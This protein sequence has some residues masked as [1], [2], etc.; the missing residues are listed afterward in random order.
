[1]PDRLELLGVVGTC[2]CCAFL[3]MTWDWWRGGRG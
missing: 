1:M 3:L 2:L